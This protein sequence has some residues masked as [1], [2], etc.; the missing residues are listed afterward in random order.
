[1]LRFN[2][3]TFLLAAIT[4][5]TLIAAYIP[6]MAA[7]TDHPVMGLL[8]RIQPGASN[9]FVIK[10][11]DGPEDYFEITAVNGK[12]AIYGNNAVNIAAGLNWYLKYYANIHL[13]WNNMT[14]KLPAKLPLP[15]KPEIH[16]TDKDL[17]YYLNYCTHSYSMAFWDWNR[18]QQEIDWMAL[19]GINLPLAITG[20]DVVWR[21]T[22]RQL[23]YNDAEI[24]EF[25]A[26][27][28]FQAW[29]LMNNL[30]GWGGPVNEQW[31]AEREKLAKKILNRMREYGMHPVLPGF[32]GMMPHDAEEKLGVTVSGK[33]DWNGFTRPVFILADD[34]KFAEIAAVYYDNLTRLYGHADYYSMDPFHEG[35]SLENIDLTNAGKIITDAMQRATPGSTWVIQGWRENP[36]PELL[37]GVPQ[38]KLLVLDLASEIRPQWG[39]PDS[40]APAKEHRPDG[41]NPHDWLYCMLLNFGGNVG[42]HGRIDYVIDEYYKARNSTYDK[43]LRGFGL[44]MEGIENNP[45]MYELASELIW[46]PEKIDKYKWIDDYVTLRYG[47]SNNNAVQAW[48]ELAQS[49]Y[50]CKPGNLQQGTTESIFCA[51]PSET[52][53]QVSSWSR[54]NKYYEPQKVIDAAMIFADAAPLLS[55]NANYKY[56][57]VDITRQAVAE[58][59]RIIH[60]RMATALNDSDIARF[61]Q[62]SDKFIRLIDMQDKLLSTTPGFMVGKWIND[63]KRLAPTPQDIDLME[64]NARRL[65]T[66]WGLRHS[67]EDEGLRDYAH[68]EWSGI[69]KD[70]YRVRWSKWIEYQKDKMQNKQV[71][72][73]DF[74]DIDNNWVESRKIYP[75]TQQGDPVQT[76]I[77]TVK[78]LRQILED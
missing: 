9:R 73:I 22:L 31:Y 17:R 32:A 34:P 23:G 72:D 70:L 50:N 6:A 39:D 19:H 2:T 25:V 27:P 76:A 55:R 59:G 53:W 5:I 4:L 11:T 14:A 71:E 24:A 48:T 75:D 45:V 49:I 42:L 60:G 26:G 51:R 7:K 28:A 12:P 74:Y 47:R 8:E 3:K 38:G 41:Y 1:M 29:W 63:A 40:P 67:S 37:Q 58:A 10:Q 36:R 30:E 18:W 62:E 33:G 77:A 52:A 15:S 43:T 78:S 13:S 65:I 35:G 16:K 56:D 64:N 54:M 61:S 20:I 21:D 46:R 66:T 57:I 44:T 68:R 69:L